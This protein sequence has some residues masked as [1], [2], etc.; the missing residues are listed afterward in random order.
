MVSPA[1]KVPKGSLEST[2]DVNP[3]EISATPTDEDLKFEMG[4]RPRAFDEYVGQEKVKE[5]LLSQ[6]ERELGKISSPLNLQRGKN[7]SLYGRK[8]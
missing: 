8:N 7:Q 5:N 2:M 3:S 6:R 1:A 4:L